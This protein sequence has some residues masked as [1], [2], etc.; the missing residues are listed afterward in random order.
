[1][2]V[3][4]TKATPP[5]AG[6]V[7][8]GWQEW[9]G[10]YGSFLQM[11]YAPDYPISVGSPTLPRV[12]ADE[13]YAVPEKPL[14]DVNQGLAMHTALRSVSPGE[15]LGLHTAYL[16]GGAEDADDRESR[17]Y[18]CPYC[19]VACTN[20][21]QLKGHLRVHTGEKP[22]RCDCG[23]AFARNEELTRHRRIHSG[24]RPHHC[25]TCGKRFGRKDHLNKY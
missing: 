1:M 23:R 5:I 17:K 8:D 24:L 3:P 4:L 9:A 7:A 20:N 18:Q 25:S 14:L 6:D 10:K 22:Y 19:D 21:G 13:T 2:P 16:D 11:L 15:P 12:P